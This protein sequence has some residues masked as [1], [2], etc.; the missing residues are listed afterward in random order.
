MKKMVIG[1]SIVI[2]VIT[3]A[4]VFINGWIK[5]GEIP[6]Q[7]KE[8]KLFPSGEQYNEG[9]SN[10]RI[11]IENSSGAEVIGMDHL[12]NI[13]MTGNLTISGS[14]FICLNQECTQW[15]KSNVSG[16]FIQG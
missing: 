3:I 10:P 9:L 16:V 15:I 5:I 14:N 8:T 12:G 11:K 7:I 1:L 13:N 4:F 6:K 2:F